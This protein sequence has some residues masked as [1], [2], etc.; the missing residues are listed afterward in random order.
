MLNFLQDVIYLKNRNLLEILDIIL[1]SNIGFVTNTIKFFTIFTNIVVNK[2][3]YYPS[4][5]PTGMVLIWA[6]LYVNLP[7]KPLRDF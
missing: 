1:S 2:T 7:E 5:I 6:K 3:S 4:Y